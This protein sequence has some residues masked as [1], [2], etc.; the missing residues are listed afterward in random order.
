ME[1]LTLFKRN[2]PRIDS[3]TT[4]H[5]DSRKVP[6]SLYF[7]LSRLPFPK[8]YAGRITLVT[9][10]GLYAPLL[11]LILYTPDPK[12]RIQTLYVIL[13]AALLGT[14]FTL[15]VLRSLLLPINLVSRSLREYVCDNRIPNLPTHLTDEL[16]RLMAGAQHTISHVDMV[17]RSLEKT[18]TIDYLTGIYNRYSGERL[19][20]EVLSRAEKIGG[21]VPIVMLDIDDFKLINDNYGHDIGDTCLKH[22]VRIIGDN[23]RRDDLLI[24]WGGDEFILVLFNSDEESSERILK[25]ILSAVQEQPICTPR[26]EIRLTVSA[27]VCYHNGKDNLERLFKKADGALLLAKRLGKCQIVYCPDPIPRLLG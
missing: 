4:G 25:R 20:R 12:S 19:L 9:L 5:P 22:V 7:L 16:G 10:F 27:G 23:I 21:T 24:R 1:R 13:I 11:A 15:Y 6:N 14:A 8:S 17:I 18:S 3:H 26:G 2:A